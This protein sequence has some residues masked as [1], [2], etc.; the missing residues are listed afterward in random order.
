MAGGY[1]RE[2]EVVDVAQHGLE[3]VMGYPDSRAWMLLYQRISGHI[4]A[5][6]GIVGDR[7]GSD[8]V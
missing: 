2:D 7:T 6:Q 8:S 5:Y 1:G 3:L 4:G